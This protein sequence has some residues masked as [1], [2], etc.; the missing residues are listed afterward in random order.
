MYGLTTIDELRR[1]INARLAKLRTYDLFLRDRTALEWL[2][3][4]SFIVH[5]IIRNDASRARHEETH[6][7]WTHLSDAEKRELV[8]QWLKL[9]EHGRRLAGEARLGGIGLGYGAKE[10]APPV[11]AAEVR[12]WA[13]DVDAFVGKF[14]SAR[15]VKRIEAR[16]DPHPSLDSAASTLKT[17]G[18]IVAVGVGGILLI[19]VLGAVRGRE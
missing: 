8:A 1:M 4:N 17:I 10:T 2:K 6:A 16:V 14:E 18:T 11:R 7:F 3:D 19:N 5:W 13:A 9:V 12:A 15:Q